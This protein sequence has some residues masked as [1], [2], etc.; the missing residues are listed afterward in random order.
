MTSKSLRV[1]TSAALLATGLGTVAVAALSPS[2]HADPSYEIAAQPLVGVGSDTVQ[3]LFNAYSGAEPSQG[4]QPSEAPNLP[5]AFYTPL[6]S[7]GTDGSGSETIAS[8]DATNPHQNYANPD[9]NDF[10][11]TKL[12]G[13]TFDRPNG[14]TDGRTALDDSV[15]GLTWENATDASNAQ[16]VKGYIDFARSTSVGSTATTG[17]TP[18]ND[19][20]YIPF[21]ADGDSYAYH[22]ANPSSADCAVLKD[23]PKSVFK[24]LYGSTTGILTPSQWGATSDSLEACGLYSGSGVFKFFLST[25]G[26]TT[27]NPSQ[28]DANLAA[29][30]SSGCA[31]VEQNNLDNFLSTAAALSTTSDWVVPLSVGSLIAQHNGFSLDRSNNFWNTNGTDIS[32]QGIAAV[33]DAGNTTLQGAVSSGATSLVIGLQAPAGT[34]LILNPGGGDQE[35][36]TVASVTGTNPYTVTLTGGTA[37]AHASGETVQMVFP[38]NLPYTGDGTATW[39]PLDPYYAGQLGRWLFVVVPSKSIGSAGSRGVVQAIAD[40]FYSPLATGGTA[41]ICSSA[42]QTLM[43][44]FGFDSHLLDDGTYHGGTCG[45]VA[46]TGTN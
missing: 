2:A 25:V 21:A 15:N 14:A 39:A 29:S 35:T 43:N 36:V 24:T 10:I 8:F 1:L 28:V 34:Q 44:D 31:N 16:A 22:C 3:D 11:T 27:Y 7:S 12:N 6:H 38:G 17:S 4:L 26:E 20:S 32:G 42:S 33:S 18:T 9:T 30:G 41:A 37:N 13:P 19:L 45:V 5:T 23:L 46:Y 40:L